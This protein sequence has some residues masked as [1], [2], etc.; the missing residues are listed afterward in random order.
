[1][2][3]AGTVHMRGDGVSP[4]RRLVPDDPWERTTGGL[5]VPRR[6]T[7]PTRR[8]IQQHGTAKECCVPICGPCYE[9]AEFAG[10]ETSVAVLDIIGT[11]SEQCAA[12]N[13]NALLGNWELPFYSLGTVGTQCQ[14]IWR[15]SFALS[16]CGVTTAYMQLTVYYDTNGEAQ[17]YN[18]YI[19]KTG[20]GVGLI[21]AIGISGGVIDFCQDFTTALI[22]GI[23]AVCRQA[24]GSTTEV[25][26][27]V[28]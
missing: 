6:P 26:F 12:A 8:H 21:S 24:P 2:V 14:A 16:V 23:G 17:G 20:F 15:E 5:V 9:G 22:S 28:G 3:D 10:I 25:S 18:I 11:W 13:C 1:M 7:L 19:G 4:R 27:I